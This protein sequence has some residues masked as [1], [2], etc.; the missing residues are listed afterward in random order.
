V[1][2]Q[3]A[4]NGISGLQISKLFCGSIPPDPLFMRGM[5]WRKSWWSGGA[6]APPHLHES[7]RIFGNVD[8]KEGWKQSFRVQMG[9]GGMSEIW[10]FC[11]KFRR[12]CPPH[13]KKWISA[14]GGMLATHVA[15]GHC[16][17]PLIYYLTE[18]SLFKK[19]P[20][21]PPPT[22]KSLKKALRYHTAWCIMHD[23]LWLCLNCF[24][25]FIS[26]NYLHKCPILHDDW[27]QSTKQSSYIL[28]PA[29][30]YKYLQ[31]L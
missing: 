26:I 31:I 29:F 14:T 5:Q 27:F 10:K 2:A 11:R 16:Y 23:G 30:Q 7:W 6:A 9:G 4:G 12:L 13:R 1:D 18:R 8:L 28:L 19:C 21:P 24:G 22:G 15:F 20:P 25:I 3:N 17:P